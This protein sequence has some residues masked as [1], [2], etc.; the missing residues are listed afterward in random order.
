M[1]LKYVVTR[2]LQNETMFIFPEYVDHSKFARHMGLP[3]SAGFINM[4]EKACY[5]KSVSLKIDS[6]PE[7]DNILLKQMLNDD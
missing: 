1:K 7:I 5:G 4:K 2:Y 3:L 6:N